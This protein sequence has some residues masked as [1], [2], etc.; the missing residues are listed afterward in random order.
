M[1]TKSKLVCLAGCLAVWLCAAGATAQAQPEAQNA[2]TPAPAVAQPAAAQVPSA[3]PGYPPPAV[4]YPPPGYAS[5]PGYYP[6]PGYAP[7]PGYYPPPGYAPPGA[8]YPQPDLGPPPGH[9]LHD[10]FYMRL[11]MGPGYLNAKYNVGGQDATISGGG[12]AMAFAFGGSVTPNLVIYGE[13]MGTVAMDPKLERGE[14]SQN[15]GFDVNLFG[16]GPGVAYYLEPMNMYFSGTLAFSQ[17]T[18]SSSSSGSSNDTADLTNM[19]IGGSFMVGKEWWVSH[20]W[21]LGIAGML[22]LAS[23]K[24]KIVDSTM[25][26]AAFSILFSATYN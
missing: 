20:D 4:A 18:A 23:M 14:T 26:A 17:V 10:G 15:T 19:G 11:T 16:I 7:P 12:M 24:M 2:A 6:P 9:H 22:H 25:T 1:E 3:A 21:G 13:F 8:Y 5:P